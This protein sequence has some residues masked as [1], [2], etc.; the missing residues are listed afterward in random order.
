MN[1]AQ[2]LPAWNEHFGHAKIQPLAST[3]GGEPEPFVLRYLERERVRIGKPRNEVRILDLG[4]GR[5]RTVA[6]LC[7]HEWNAWGADVSPDYLRQ[8][9]G[10]FERTGFG[11]DRL[12]LISDSRDLPFE[13]KSF[14]IVI[15][16][17]VF[18]HVADIDA[19][20]QGLRGV[21]RYGGTGVHIFPAAKRPVE[22]HMRL[23]FVHWLPKGRVRRHA[24]RAA[25]RLGQGASYF[26]DYSLDDRAEIFWRFSES[27]TYYRK[28]H[29]IRATFDRHSIDCDFATAPKDKLAM[30]MP[31]VP[32]ALI[33]PAALIY[34]VFGATYLVTTART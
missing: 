18:E 29:E 23:P 31:Q 34:R 17:Q 16:D 33:P 4:C 25:L 12:R 19:V 2:R 7:A 13:P 32:S 11:A 10:Y 6:W 30:R 15:S 5:G 21:M 28:A 14:D 9:T 22:S 27:E 20:A 3:E 26:S 1:R 24:I 8:G